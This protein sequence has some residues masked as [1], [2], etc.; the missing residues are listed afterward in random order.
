MMFRSF[1][2]LLTATTLSKSNTIFQRSIQ[3]L[4]PFLSVPFYNG[5]GL[6]INCNFGESTRELQKKFPHLTFLGTE[7]DEEKIEIAR[8]K[9]SDFHFLNLDIEK[10][11]IPL[12]DQFQIIQISEYDSFWSIIEKSFDLLDTDGL[13]I[14]KFKEEDLYEV[15]KLLNMKKS[16]KI[17]NN[18]LFERVYLSDEDNKLFL[19]K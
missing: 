3:S 10:K 2:C 9:N 7:K 17:I 6:D 14:I 19:L 15:E 8:K 5:L 12:I 16:K 4:P 1:V 18:Q 11:E 13:L